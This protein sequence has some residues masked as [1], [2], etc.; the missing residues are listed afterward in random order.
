MI[1]LRRVNLDTD[2][3]EARDRREYRWRPLVVPAAAAHRS[4]AVVYD[5]AGVVTFRHSMLGEPLEVPPARQYPCVL[6]TLLALD[7]SLSN[8]SNSPRLASGSTLRQAFDAEYRTYLEQLSSLPPSGPWEPDYGSYVFD[9]R[10]A[11]LYLVAPEFWH[12]LALL[13]SNGKLNT[14]PAGAMT[15]EQI[16]DRL[17]GTVVGF[18][19]A[20]LGS[21][22]VEGVMR[23]M[24]PTAA[25]LADPDYLEATNLNRLQHGS[26]RYLSEPRAARTDLR[27][28]FETHFVNKVHL[29]A[30]E[31][32]L[33]DPYMDFYLYEEGLQPENIERFLLGGDGEPRLDYVVEEA[34]DLRIKIEVRR[35]ARAH[36][37]P[38]FMAS[39]LGNRTQF[40][41]Q[42]YATTPDA[43]LGY[44]VSDAE[45]AERVELC[46][47]RGSREDRF[48]AAAALLGSDFATDEFARWLQQEG[49][50][51]TSSIPQSGSVAL[52]GGALTGKLLALHRL[53]HP[54]C[55][56]LVFDT[57]RLTL[58]VN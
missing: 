7:K 46:M 14:D 35:Q 47:S 24:R 18:V 52:L 38:V 54:L 19:G 31:N 53:G 26:L 55:E 32:Q 13:A 30:Y 43:R 51:P 41:L 56:R 57:R 23:E 48:R 11:E 8:A 1:I 27:S 20:S 5:S 33:V 4:G 16:R 6:P 44:G 39:D 37:I 36:G 22:V 58:I 9:R 29:V 12:R 21:N 40:Q 2:A 10:T 17:A 3:K 34:D 28:A 50:Q 49:E 25:K 42:D 45:L 15:A